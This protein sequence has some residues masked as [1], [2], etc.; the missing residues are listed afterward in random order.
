MSTTPDQLAA[1]LRAAISDLVRT[2]RWI[3]QLAPIPAAVLDLLDTRGPMTTA[4]LAASRG[5]RHQT[6]AATIKDLTDAGFVT[7]S[8]DPADARKKIL[9]LTAAGRT[10][11]E[12]DRHQ[13][14]G[15]L[16]ATI[17]GVLDAEERR[18]LAKALAL[19][20]RLTKAVADDRPSS[21][22]DR[23]PITGAW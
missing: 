17:A 21:A 5:V 7:A 15:L 19:I 14:V 11:I 4:D 13:R 23:E 1:H 22:T 3:D 8:P 2:T 16:S 18:D 10:A 9:A 6:M 12:H 20:D